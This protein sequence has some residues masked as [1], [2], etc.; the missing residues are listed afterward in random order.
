[1]NWDQ[2]N[3]GRVSETKNP[4]M[5]SDASDLKEKEDEG[6]RV[7]KKDL[8]IDKLKPIKIDSVNIK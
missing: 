2:E 3:K 6:F 7:D 1:M 8:L 5:M 4:I